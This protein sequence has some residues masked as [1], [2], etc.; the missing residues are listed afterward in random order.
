MTEHKKAP[1]KALKQKPKSVLQDWFD[2]GDIFF[3]SKDKTRLAETLNEIVANDLGVAI[4]GSNEVILDHYC[5]MLVGRMREI[6]RFQSEAFLPV[7]TDSLLIRFNKMLSEISLEQAAK[8]PLAGQPVRLL[9]I[10]DA[11]VV[12]QAR[13]GLLTRLLVDFPGVNA[14]LV[15]VINKSGWP[16]HENLL[17]TL[18][19]KM[20]RWVV[21]APSANEARQL[22][23]NAAEC[24]YLAETEALLVDAG[25]GA[26]IGSEANAEVDEQLD[27]D[28]PVMPEL[29]IDVLLGAAAD[30]E[31]VEEPDQQS[32][33]IKGRRWPKIMIVAGSLIVS[34]L[35]ILSLYPDA[36][37]SAGYR[38]E[39]I[40]VP[41]A[42]QVEAKRLAVQAEL[43][44]ATSANQSLSVKSNTAAV[45]LV[46]EIIALPVAD[47]SPEAPATSPDDV[48][49][50]AQEL[51]DSVADVQASALESAAARIAEASRSDYFIQH[52]VL[53]EDLARAYIERYSVLR[54]ASVVPVRINQKN[55]FAVVSGPFRS[56]SAAALFTQNSAVPD[57]YWIRGAAELQAILRRQQ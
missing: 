11:R 39:S 17:Q 14:R 35:V 40:E 55:A 2:G 31:L 7:T 19:K 33:S 4:I 44:A 10:N 47:V 48:K 9:I 20:H 25:M 5:R 36:E 27:P 41:S 12:D 38:V 46:D 43:E 56:R 29:D 49:P 28:L 15:L 53:T 50:S 13:W 23:S 24:G 26:V 3:R 6:E 8:P 18:G 45:S 57:D 52:I 30:D 22:L 42:E 37:P 1:K 16:A 51:S 54:D 32:E 34:L 21:E